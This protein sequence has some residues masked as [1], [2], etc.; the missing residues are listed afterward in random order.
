LARRLAVAVFT[1]P[2]LDFVPERPK[3][4]CFSALHSGCGLV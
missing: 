2:Q 3:T 4:A 1:T